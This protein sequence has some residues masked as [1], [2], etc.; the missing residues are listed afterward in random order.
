MRKLEVV[1]IGGGVYQG[2]GFVQRKLC[3]N[4]QG[5]KVFSGTAA[6]GE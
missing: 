6:V 4:G 2:I 5:K 1:Q 3:G